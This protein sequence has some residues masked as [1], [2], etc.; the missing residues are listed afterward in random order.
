LALAKVHAAWTVD[1][2]KKILWTDES[3]F[4]S[5]GIIKV[6]IKPNEEYNKNC[7]LP[8]VK[9]GGGSIMVWGLMSYSGAGGLAVIDEIMTKIVYVR[10]LKENLD[11]SLK[12]AG[13][14]RRYIFQQDQDPKHTSNLAKDYFEKKKVN[15]LHWPPQSPDLNPI[16]HLWSYLKNLL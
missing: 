1:D 13:L 9:H 7:I 11:K 2:W 3:K 8:T 15:V 16:E 5:D 4:G 14:A 6:W 12:K 10:P